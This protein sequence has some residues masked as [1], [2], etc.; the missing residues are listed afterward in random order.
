MNYQ[1]S[2]KNKQKN[3]NK[4]LALIIIKFLFKSNSLINHYPVKIKDNPTAVNMNS[5]P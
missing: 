3:Y 1:I 2:I 5:D 4:Y